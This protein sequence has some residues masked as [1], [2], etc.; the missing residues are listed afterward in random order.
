MSTVAVARMTAKLASV[1]DRRHFTVR[2]R[3]HAASADVEVDVLAA[4]AG[5]V[6]VRDVRRDRLLAQRGPGEGAVEADL[7]GVEE[8]QGR[9]TCL[10]SG[11]GGRPSRSLAVASVRTLRGH[12]D[13]GARLSGRVVAVRAGSNARA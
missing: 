13:S 9:T 11:R 12:R 5:G 4:V 7:S 1:R 8:F 2:A 3:P 10:C 6:D